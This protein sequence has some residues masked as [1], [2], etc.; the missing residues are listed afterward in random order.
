MKTVPNETVRTSRSHRLTER[1]GAAGGQADRAQSQQSEAAVVEDVPR[2][3]R[4]RTFRDRMLKT[5]EALATELVSEIVRRG[6]K[7]GD[8]LPQES[9]MIQ[10]YG[11]GRSTVRE[12]LRILEVNGLIEIRSGPRGGPTVCG[13]SPADF[14]RMASFFLQTERV[15]F[16]ELLNARRLLEPALAKEATQRGDPAFLRKIADLRERSRTIDVTQDTDYL[17]ITREFHE[18]IASGSANRLLVLFA[19]GLMSMFVVRLDRG[20][21]PVGE[22]KGVMVEHDRVL[23]AILGGNAER[24]ERFMGVHMDHFANSIATRQPDVFDEIISWK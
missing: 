22:R 5:S 23:A 1:N 19:L 14:G 16:G 12:A 9:A 17:R 4:L 8:Q 11:A 6:L 15:T 3:T 7:P 20:V 21:F 18:F 24:A 10:R 13:A 2:T